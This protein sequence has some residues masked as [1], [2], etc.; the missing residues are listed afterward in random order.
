M[1]AGPVATRT[2]RDARTEPAVAVTV[3]VPCPMDVTTPSGP[4]VAIVVLAADQ[5][6]SELGSPCP[7]P[8]TTVAVTVWLFCNSVKR[9]SSSLSVTVAGTR[10]TVTR[11][12][13][14]MFT[15]RTTISAV[16]S[17]T[18]RI[19]PLAVTVTTAGSVVVQLNLTSVAGVPSPA[20]SCAVAP[21]K[22]RL[23]AAGESAIDAETA[24]GSSGSRRMPLE[25]G[26]QLVSRVTAASNAQVQARAPVWLAIKYSVQAD[27]KLKRCREN[28]VP[29]DYLSLSYSR[30]VSHAS[31]QSS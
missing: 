31:P 11:V 30:S 5:T 29:D 7:P 27:Q 26:L 1:S 21:I 20:T 15:V 18:A 10:L 3:V 22:P 4:T 19:T 23:V 25:S 2:V 14:T 17:V 16:P 8:S 9:N 6:M 28:A 24:S 12:V 13:S